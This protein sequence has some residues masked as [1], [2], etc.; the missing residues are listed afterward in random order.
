MIII[1][2]ATG[3]I[4]GHL[5]RNLNQQHVAIRLVGRNA[6]KLQS[7][8][9]DADIACGDM[10]DPASLAPAFQ[11]GKRLFLLSAHGP[12]MEQQ[13]INA[14]TVATQQGFDHIVKIS[15]SSQSIAPD[16]VS[17][18]GQQHF[19]IEAALKKSGIPYT[20]L[21]PTFFMQNL[22]DMPATFVRNGRPIMMPFNGTQNL[23]FID[24]QDIAAAAAHI[25]QSDDFFG[26]IVELIG[27]DGTFQDVAAI[28]SQTIGRTVSYKALP[29]WISSI[30]LRLR[31]APPW[32]RRHQIQMAKLFSAQGDIHNKTDI[33][34]LLGREPASLADFISAHSQ[35]FK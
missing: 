17:D 11:G 5:A 30:A 24:A 7:L 33:T 28:V 34:H 26:Q 35:D 12:D 20:I 22:L 32:Q 6:D 18:M 19:R 4:G 3:L 15:G 9:L 10:N 13:Q 2:G 8:G 27:D 29:I 31:G 21:R 25:L 14:I 1:L 16:S 23:T